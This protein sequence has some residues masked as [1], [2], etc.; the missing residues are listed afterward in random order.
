MA[1][2]LPTLEQIHRLASDFGLVLTAEEVSAFQQAFKGP[3]SSYGR[4]D[5]LVPPSLAP[6]APRAPGYRPP[7]SEN[8]YGAW[9][10]KTDIRSGSEGLL[11][12]KKVAIKD[13]ICVAGVPMMNGSALLEGYVPEMDA[14]VVTRILDGGGTIA[15][16]AACEDLCFSGASHTCATG[17]IRN[18]YNPQHSAGGSSGG[19]AAL[20][21]SGEVPMA[22]GGDQGGSIRTPSSWCG[23]YGLKPTFGLVPT[24]GSMPISYSVD[25]C[26][27]MCASVEDVA[28]LL[29]VIAGHDGWDTRTIAARTGD[30]MGALSTSARGL[31]VG[32]LREGFGH[33]E[34]DPEVNDKVRQTIA[35]LAKAGVTSA[36]VSVPWHLDGPHVW[37][38]VI[39]EGAAEMMLKGYG[40]G[41]NVQ[42]Y[43][44]VS[45][46]EAL[47]RGMG[48]R[49]NDVSPTVKLVLV[50]G[51]Y[52]HRNYHGRYHSKAQNLRV[53]LR[54]AYDEALQHFDVLAMPTIP[55]TATAIPPADAPLT[56]VI[57]TAL[58]MQ[59]N[60][61]SFDVSGHPA[62]TVPCGRLN[63][64]PVGMMLVGRHFEEASLIRLA[65][66]IEASGDWKLN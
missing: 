34:S 66:A 31:R 49:I 45:M 41:N 3:L 5:E 55:F 59:A 42:G 28:R 54:R 37:S 46:Q 43:Y 64:L 57:D 47:A 38:G 16:K 33:R 26:G 19:S 23:V 52:M 11:S 27:P 6:V 39:L 44:P 63:G 61:C 36:E 4:L 58:N 62:F 12:G 8:P 10:W 50:L 14:T 17:V 53:L 51:E 7:A 21:A 13:N 9:Y 15:G 29:T 24:T 40:V 32:V 20:V 18:P 2:R 22:L 65:H 48:T 1:V 25:H 56:T 35:A 60:T 30:Y